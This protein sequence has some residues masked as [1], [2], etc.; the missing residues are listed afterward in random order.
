MRNKEGEPLLVLQVGRVLRRYWW[1]MVLS[2]LAG[3]ASSA[4]L[5]H[6]GPAV[7]AAT[8]SAAVG[9][10]DRV[11]N[12]ET[13]LRSL[14]TASRRNVIATYAQI[15]SSRT[16]R[17]R[18]RAQLSSP[19]ES[20]GD[21]RVRTSVIPDTNLL[22]ITVEGPDPRR[23]ADFANAVLRQSQQLAPQFYD[24]ILS[25]QVLDAAAAASQPARASS[26]RNI[27]LGV[28]LGALTGLLLAFGAQYLALS[29]APGAG[30]EKQHS[31][32]R[33]FV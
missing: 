33:H 9:P 29:R 20:W 31:E 15:P 5:T 32:A 16:V 21:Y 28:L 23:A 10:S 8:A 12:I 30:Q 24:G 17:D 22:R 27:A 13:V 1:L 7:Y 19:G 26:V 18:A 14:D 6:R 11:E 3:G 25:F 4:Y 2:L